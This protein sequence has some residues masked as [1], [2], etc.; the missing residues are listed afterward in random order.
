MTSRL[1]IRDMPISGRPIGP[2]PRKFGFRKY[3]RHEYPLVFDCAGPTGNAFGILGAARRQM[4]RDGAPT[5]EIIGM[6]HAAQQGDYAHLLEV[7]ERWV[8]CE[9]VNRDPAPGGPGQS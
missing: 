4:E 2:N 3:G 9:F 8:W 5:Q 1:P 6:M 7:V